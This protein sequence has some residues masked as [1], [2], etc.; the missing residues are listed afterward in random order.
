MKICN[1]ILTLLLAVNLIFLTAC[2]NINDI[3]IHENT[4]YSQLQEE[5][6][7]Y[8]EDFYSQE[9]SSS[10]LISL[11]EVISESSLSSLNST[12]SNFSSKI[13]SSNSSSKTATSSKKP[14]S[15]S[16][17]KPS[18]SS[19]KAPSSTSSKTPSSSVGS[20]SGYSPIYYKSPMKAVWI[21]QFNIADEMQSSST[22]V[23]FRTNIAN[24]MKTVKNF[25]FNTVVVQLRPNGDAFYSS[26]YYPWS[27]YCT[28]TVGKAPNY[29]P[30][31]ILI[32]EAHKLGLSFHAW[33][34]PLR[35]ETESNMKKTSI[36]FKT[37]QWYNTKKGD[38]VVV[39]NS[40]CYLNPAYS[41]VRNLIING[42]KEIAL[43]YNVDAL[44]IDDYFYPTTAAS[45]D[46]IAY[47]N[48][49][50][51]NS[52]AY[53]RRNN[54]NT[55]V[56]GIYNA[57]K[58]VNSRIKFGISPAGNINN[59]YNNLYADVSLWGKSS[60]YMDYCMPQ[61]YFGYNHNTLD[62]LKNLNQWKN[63]ITNTNIDLVIGLAAYKIGYA[64]D[65]GSNEWS[66][67]STILK[68]QVIDAKNG[69][70]TKYKGFCVFS[71]DD[72]F[73]TNSLNTSFRNNLK[74]VM[75]G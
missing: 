34:N 71:Y 62:Y 23:A 68:R 47:K 49:G 74:Q 25:G 1:K 40:Y 11:D 59:N 53:F 39:V 30:T 21:S 36:N 54:I 26:S 18:A 15:T 65:G 33:F 2:S 64:Q 28:G 10:S 58:S 16:S 24:I 46:S 73:S 45:F 5:S 69:L 67:D 4:D 37:R 41:E 43:K 75:N 29:D 20:S 42:A 60:G 70:G 51:S 19:T 7:S 12:S 38:Y 17:K 9:I 61:I 48:L 6:S 8:G 50:G 55:L 31:A 35:L 66:K 13:T 14:F 44:H 22:A 63:T 32:D 72:L 56:K 57:V 27:R 52:L 3:V